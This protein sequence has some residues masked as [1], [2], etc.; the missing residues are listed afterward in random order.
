MV[1]PIMRGLLILTA[2]CVSAFLVGCG[3]SSHSNNNGGGGGG[4]GTANN[5][6]SI[7]V[8][9][10]PVAGQIYANGAFTSVT[11]CVPNS[12]TCQTVDGI[13]VDTGS[14][15]LRIL[16]SVIPSLSL[17][18]M[19]GSGGTTFYN[20]VSFVD[21][22]FLWGAV[23]QADVEISGEKAS[24]ASIQLIGDPTGF[25]VPTACSNGGVDVSNLARLGANGIIGVG[26]FPQDCGQACAPSQGGTPPPVYFT[27]VASGNCQTAFV[28]LAQ[29]IVNPVVRFATDNNGVILE[30]QSVNVASATA[31]GSMIFGI[32]TQSNNTLG[33]ADFF[34]LGPSGFMTTLFNQKTLSESFIDSGSNGYFFPD[35]AIPQCG[36]NSNAPGFYCP[37][38]PMNLRAQNIDLNNAQNTVNFTVD[39]AVSDFQSNGSDAAFSNLAGS[40]G[41]DTCSGQTPCGFDW[42]MPFFYGRHVFTSI[43]GQA[44]PSGAPAAPWWAY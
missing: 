23:A 18:L 11:V 19:T 35:S 41:S 44:V 2:S 12:S 26:P 16:Q 1:S 13:L 25:T 40:N 38:G 30:M 10:G 21:R 5:V 31:T 39:N 29:Q 20:C 37:T 15:G 22:S 33:S 7:A 24:A 36:Q 17:P 32:G 6:Q 14:F 28:A 27:C 4:G 9:G 8:N 43:A 3:G 42:G 34:P